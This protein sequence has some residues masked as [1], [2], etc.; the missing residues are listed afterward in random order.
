MP[1]PYSK[2]YEGLATGLY[3]TF[4][5]KKLPVSIAYMRGAE[6]RLESLLSG[7]YDFVVM[8]KLAAQ[9]S[10]SNGA[11]IEIIMNFGKYTYVSEHALIFN[12][13]SNNCIKDGMKIGIDKTSIDHYLITMNQCNG[14]DV[15]LIDLAYNQ[16]IS[17]VLSGDKTQQFGIL[18]KL[19]R[20]KS[21][22]S[23]IHLRM[24]HSTKEIRRQL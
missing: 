15:E 9:H 13:P 19:M 23:I 1:L 7:R 20:E 11:N 4:S 16:I 2:L 21:I 18:M 6:S 17:K 8:S 3:K 14:K 24:I 12:D 10:I 22:L 5:S